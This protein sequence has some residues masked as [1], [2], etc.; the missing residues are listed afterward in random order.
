MRKAALLLGVLF[1]ACRSTSPDLVLTNGK[2]FTADPGR[3]WAEAL[4]IRGERIAA[5]GSA[6]EV[7]ALAGPQ[8]RVIDLRGRVVVPGINDAHIHEPWGWPGE[9]ADVP[10]SATADQ[11]LATVVE[12]SKRVPRGAWIQATLPFA[13]KHLSPFRIHSSPLRSALSL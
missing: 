12:M 10:E 4:A 11:L 9:R 13:M 3:P 6:A 5:V 7:R 1:A 8:T 2:V